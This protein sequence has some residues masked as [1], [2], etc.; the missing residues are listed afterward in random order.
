M[1]VAERERLDRAFVAL[2][3]ANDDLRDAL[4]VHKDATTEAVRRMTDGSLTTEGIRAG[5]APEIREDLTEAMDRFET[6]RRE[7][8]LAVFAYLSANS[9]ES[10][11]EIG[12]S[13]GISRQ[14]AS[15]LAREA[16]K[17]PE[18]SQPD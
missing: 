15:K 1:R 7:A 18:S 11:S 16:A 4:L 12:R 10:F 6:A 13:L 17:P 3:A 9:D 2:Q 8:R 14:L 5:A